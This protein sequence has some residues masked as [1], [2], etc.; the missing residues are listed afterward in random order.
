MFDELL[1][2][3]PA[4]AG[5]VGDHGIDVP[6]RAARRS[7]QRVRCVGI[8]EVSGE[9]RDPAAGLPQFRH[10]RLGPTR[11][12]APRLLGVVQGPVVQGPGVE[13]DRRSFGGHAPSERGADPTASAGTGHDHDPTS[14]R[15]CHHPVDHGLAAG[16]RSTR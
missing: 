3:L 10:Q 14:Q 6:E 1:Q 7:D 2:R 16:Q 4:A 13:H 5:M 11:I 15:P 12:G 9:G 8:G